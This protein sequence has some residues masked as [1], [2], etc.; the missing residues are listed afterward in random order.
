[1][2]SSIYISMF[3]LSQSFSV[4]SSL[5]ILV[6]FQLLNENGKLT[7]LVSSRAK[8]LRVRLQ[9]EWFFNRFLF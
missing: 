1:M 6:D 9:T 2:E 5:Q 4:T 3:G 7:L 8:W